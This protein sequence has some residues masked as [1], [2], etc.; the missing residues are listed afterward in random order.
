MRLILFLFLFSTVQ[1]QI[2]PVLWKVERDTV[3]QWYYFFGDEFNGTKVNE[4]IWHPKYPWG[5]LLADEGSYADKKMVSQSEGLL[6]L[7]ADTVSEWLSLI[8]I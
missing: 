8:H 4:G 2:E 5:G 3:K 7:S 6:K 1:A